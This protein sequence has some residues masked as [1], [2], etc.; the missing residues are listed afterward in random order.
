MFSDKEKEEII[1]YLINN[2][3]DV[4]LGC[5][6]IKFKNKRGEWVARYAVVLVVHKNNSNGC[7]IFG[8]TREERDY[9]KFNKPRTRLM[10]EVYMVA[11][12]YLEFAPILE[13]RHVEVHL[14]LNPDEYH[15]SNRVAKQ[16]VGYIL[17]VTGITPMI[18]PEAFAA[19]YAAD[20]SVRSK[21][22][23]CA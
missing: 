1:D 17:G 22:S 18:K 13:G 16:A 14:D 23:A 8:Y 10:N 3:G 5:D 12:C 21:L 20:A 15:E 7:K 4:Y 2:E 6:S 19:S 11:E 9:D